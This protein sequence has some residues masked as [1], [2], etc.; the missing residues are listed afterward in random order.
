MLHTDMMMISNNQRVQK[1]YQVVT[2]LCSL[3]M[4]KVWASK[5]ETLI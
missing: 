4:F 1:R 2:I 5:F 3:V